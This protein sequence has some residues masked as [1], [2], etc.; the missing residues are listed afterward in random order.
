[1]NVRREINRALLVCAAILIAIAAVVGWKQSVTLLQGVPGYLALLLLA[2]L[3][4]FFG[5]IYALAA[6]ITLGFGFW[7]YIL[8]SAF[9]ERLAGLRLVLFLVA[10]V[11]IVAVSRRRA[12]QLVEAEE[13][14]RSL[15]E[16]SPDGIGV[17]DE[18]ARV[19]YA[20]RAL[21][22]IV[23]A[24]RLDQVLGKSMYEFIHPDFRPLAQERV[25]RV[26]AGE[27]IHPRETKWLTLDGRAVDVEGVAVAVRHSGRT[28]F[29]GFVRDLTERNKTRAELDA[30]A[31]RMHALF[32]SA[33][34][35][36]AFFDRDGLYLD[37]NPAGA[38]MLDR[39]REDVI[40]KRI[41]SFT[42]SENQSSLASA[43]EMMQRGER[44]RGEFTLVRKDGQLRDVELVTVPFVLPD[45]HA[46]F[47]HDI[48]DRKRAERT[49]QK[50]SALL[51]DAETLGQT[52]SWEQ[53]LVSGEIINTDANRRLFFGD[54]RSK[55]ERIEDYVEVMHP[56]DRARVLESR[57][58]LHAGTGDGDIEYRVIW[59]D[60]SLHWIFGRA[61]IVRDE[62]GRPL[63][64]YGT[65]RDIT[66]RKRSQEEL[67][68]RAE[69]LSALSSR[70]LQSQDEERRRIARELHD[71]TAQ[72]L[73]ALR[74]NLSLL[75]RSATADAATSETI[76]E[77]IAL[78][79]RA[80]A[81][82]RTLSY[83][84]HPPMIDEAGLLP[85]L[86]WYAEGFEQR[87]GIAVTL[88]VP[89][90]LER[91]PIETETAIFRIVQE[92]LTNIQRHSG[93]AVAMIRI[94]RDPE[95]LKLEIRDEGC[96]VPAALRGDE[97]RL[98]AAGVGIAG[99]RE[100]AAELGGKM[101]IDSNDGGTTIA[102]QLPVAEA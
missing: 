36:I 23:G 52:G 17:G 41:G 79:E 58:R 57:E 47:V 6:T 42:A 77:S 86:R 48:T 90:E 21:L 83:L 4:R 61:T 93:S 11:A 75:R 54:D 88:D 64:A 59:P 63:R 9:P 16:L 19:V 101:T 84:L 56:D 91:L 44:V 8:P 95:M 69:Q 27:A 76:E 35:G 32:D 34:D 82:I 13:R 38:A 99:M 60:G 102:V 55:G 3:A 65:N 67:T 96:G 45:S 80:I 22:R 49:S 78:T 81:E 18:K 72:N 10:A 30:T 7:F 5:L 37:V 97:S 24:T 98:A 40:G 39:T 29:Q 89:A 25:A 71:T 74:M 28:W 31:R 12:A 62:A 33:I 46:V 92:A 73:G 51:I 70:L 100:R 87:S 50:L 85:S 43:W 15:V 14:Y 53:D 26:T 1:M 20:N 66:E 2:L 68:R 94:E